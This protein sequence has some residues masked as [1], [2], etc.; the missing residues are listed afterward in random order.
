MKP[1]AAASILEAHGRTPASTGPRL[2]G[3]PVRVRDGF[4][5]RHV[6]PADAAFDLKL[7]LEELFTNMVKYHPEGAEAI[8]VR[9]EHEVSSVRATLQDFDVD[10]WDVT[11]AAALDV[12]APIE[13]RQPGGMGLHLV[14]MVTDEFRYEYR[15]RSSTI[16]VTKRLAP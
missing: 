13:A 14:R 1:A 4:A 9:L 7:A 12:N 8:L 6:V 5:E 3:R 16:T 10:S 15:E 11:R 2:S